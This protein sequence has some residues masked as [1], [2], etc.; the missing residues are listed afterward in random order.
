[1]ATYDVARALE[2]L[3]IEGQKKGRRIWALCPH[4]EHQDRDPS[5]FIW[6][7][8]ETKRAGLHRCF[9]CNYKGNLAQLV[10]YTLQ[11]PPRDDGAPDL[12]AAHE[13]LKGDVVAQPPPRPVTVTVGASNRSAFEL[14]DGV[15]LIPFAEWPSGIRRYLLKRHVTAAQVAR[16]G[17]GYAVDGRLGG[18]VV[19]VVRD[20]TGVP[21]S[22]TGRAYDSDGRR[23]LN[24]LDYEGA[25]KAAIFGEQHWPPAADRS[26]A[27]VYAAE[28]AFKVLAIERALGRV[29]L[30]G[31]MGSRIHP[32]HL[33]KL[34]AF[35][36]V[37]YVEDHGAAGF[38]AAAK[39]EASLARHLSFSRVIISNTHDADDIPIPDLRRILLCAT[40]TK[41]SMTSTD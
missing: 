19:L 39:L 27:A 40:G 11:L 17:L 22:Y 32:K 5:W 6:S 12:R 30:A 3:G 2:R 25:D 24:P 14:P 13:W 31:L 21:V 23:Y 36:R 10:A 18:R 34:S 8:E 9:S 4:R 41:N 15:R 37:V 29:P 33:L 38:K 35:G 7:T 28:G 16:W 1:M 20:A 26:A